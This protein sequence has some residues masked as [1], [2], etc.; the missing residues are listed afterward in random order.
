[1]IAYKEKIR[2]V[3]IPN[4]IRPNTNLPLTIRKLLLDEITTDI[5]KKTPKVE[6]LSLKIRKEINIHTLNK[7]EAFT[8]ITGVD[9]GSQII[10]LA[11]RQYA[12]ISALA[13]SLP[14][15]NK[16]FHLP[17]SISEN[18]VYGVDRFPGKVN[19]IREAKLFETAYQ[20][21][22]SRPEIQLMLV[23]GPLALS[24]HWQRM[25][26]EIDRKRLINAIRRLLKRCKEKNIVIAGVVKRPSARYLIYYLGLHKET[27]LSDSYIM[28]QTLNPGERTDVFSP[29][30]AMRIATRSS[31]LM[32]ALD[33]QI[34]S[35]YSRL[36]KEWSLP[37]IR[38]DVPAY[39]LSYID[40]IANYCYSTSLWNG[41][42]LAIL[43]ADEEVKISKRFIND[44]YSEIISKVSKSN[45]DVSF[46]APYWGEGRWMG[47]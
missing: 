38:I 23:D 12:V 2:A 21:I 40:E 26:K 7:K 18:Y 43:K 17:E 29:Q 34:Y 39:S 35:F 8:F 47:V 33:T 36:S 20:C 22:E 42:P 30:I 31:P 3:N 10:P 5:V 16:Y 13:F 14:N 28:L 19:V 41:I 44:V 9:A 37:P 24:N 25:G 6:E 11:S 46:L 1:V 32:D 45:V 15:G 27:D 4:Q